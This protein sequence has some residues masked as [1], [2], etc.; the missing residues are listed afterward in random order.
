MIDTGYIE[1]ILS[2]RAARDKRIKDNPQSW[3]ALVGLF[4]L[5]E[6]D[7]PFGA[8][9]SNKITLEKCVQARCGSFHLENGKIS[10]IPLSNSNITINNL[11]PEHRFLH[12][13]HDEEPDMIRAGSL[14]MKILIRGQDYYLRVWD[15][16]S[17]EV[18][19]FSGL[20]YFPVKPEYQITAK[21][22]AYDPPKVIKIQDVIGTVYDGHLFGEA[23][24]TLHGITCTLVAEEDDDELLFSFTDQT[25]EDSTYPGGRFMTAKKPERDQVTLDFNQALNWPCAYTAF[26]TCPLPPSE[27]R[28]SVRIEAGE[29]RYRE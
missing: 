2:L 15:A 10:L 8:D 26:A 29:R 5:E 3:L 7:N 18:K 11:I 28:L 27:N 1:R 14:T 4:H 6:G 25:H 20:E 21:F 17:P 22:I 16:E 19:K 13:D 23:H 9:A 12:A 24:F